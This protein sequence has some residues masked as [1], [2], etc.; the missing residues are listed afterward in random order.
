MFTRRTALI[1]SVNFRQKSGLIA[2][3]MASLWISAGCYYNKAQSATLISGGAVA[4]LS[5]SSTRAIKN[6]NRGIIHLT[7][8]GLHFTHVV[9]ATIFGCVR[10][11]IRMRKL[12][13]W[14]REQWRRIYDTRHTATTWLAYALTNALTSMGMEWTAPSALC[15]S[16]CTVDFSMRELEDGIQ[17]M[18][19]K[20]YNLCLHQLR[21][22]LRL[23]VISA[24]A[25]RLPFLFGDLTAG[26]AED[27]EIRR[28]THSL[29]FMPG[30]P[31]LLSGAHW[32]AWH[33][34]KCG[35]R[36]SNLCVRCGLE[37]ESMGHRLWRCASNAVFKDWL[38][39]VLGYWPDES[40]LPKCFSR[41]A[42]VP[43]S[44]DLPNRDCV[45][46]QRYMLMVNH[47]AAACV[48]SSRLLLEHPPA[49]VRTDLFDIALT[50]LRSLAIPPVTR[51]KTAP[52]SATPYSFNSKYVAEIY[53]DGSYTKGNDDTES[54]AGFGIAIARGPN[55]VVE[56]C[57]PVP[58]RTNHHLFRGA[59]YYSNNIAELQGIVMALEIAASLPSGCVMLG[60][61][62]EF[63]H[64]ICTGEWKARSC[65]RLAS[66]GR[67]ALNTLLNTHSVE[68]RHIDSH[69][70]HPLNELA[71]VLAGKGA[72]GETL[73][74]P[75]A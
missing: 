48:A 52:T 66:R 34:W 14:S 41:C 71:D 50:R 72:A 25:I 59:T 3:A 4:Q 37:A 11:A 18:P 70:G 12:G 40:I 75:L 6:G 73:W 5:Y 47:H 43:A 10:Q 2:D 33:S 16:G 65:A 45:T 74:R 28:A 7:G 42:L 38:V 61:D 53:C 60:Y 62:S 36:S 30:G 67:H 17:A 68:W 29:R 35:Y 15:F 20:R 54:I 69:T 57:S 9:A 1:K 21:A 23:A 22:L 49:V 32:T 51:A 46:I 55:S 56:Y 63:A 19:R 26:W 58:L 64:R 8:P 39:S 27:I 24:E 31:G 13:L 44:L